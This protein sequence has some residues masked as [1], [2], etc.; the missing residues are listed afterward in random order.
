[1]VILEKSTQ[2]CYLVLLKL[3]ILL[4]YRQTHRRSTEP[5]K[6][7]TT[8]VIFTQANSKSETVFDVPPS[9]KSRKRSP[10]PRAPGGRGVN[11]AHSQTFPT[12]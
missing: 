4:L 8:F 5:K 2:F 11:F 12:L 7:F 1:M 9:P 3:L 6:R 10:Q